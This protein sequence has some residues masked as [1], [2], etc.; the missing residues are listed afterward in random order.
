MEQEI[1]AA[2]VVHDGTRILAGPLEGGAG[3]CAADYV[4]L[5][6]GGA[7]DRKVPFLAV[8]LRGMAR[9]EFDADVVK[10]IGI[11]K[12]IIWLMTCVRDADDLFDVFNG[13]AD[14]ILV[15]YHL[16]TSDADLEDMHSVSE[17]IIPA[18]FVTRGEAE[19][20]NGRSPPQEAVRKLSSMGFGTVA[21]IDTD[22]G[23]GPGVWDSMSQ[24]AEIISY[25]K[26]RADAGRR[27]IS[28]L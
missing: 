13:E 24:A 18:L 12:H 10:S 3:E 9:G 14:I 2:N 20:R 17:S 11:K 7:F 6:S 22:A 25:S 23:L 15:P 21:V 1:P 28:S 4:D 16:T 8:D 27:F 19:C 26:T 5:V